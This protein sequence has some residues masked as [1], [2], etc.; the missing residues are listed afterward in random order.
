MAGAEGD[1]AEGPEEAERFRGR[2]L[3]L[4]RRRLHGEEAVAPA[5]SSGG[6][7]VCHRVQ[8]QSRVRVAGEVQRAG[9]GLVEQGGGEGGRRG[10]GRRRRRRRGRGSQQKQQKPPPPPSR[11]LS[12]GTAEG[13]R[14]SQVSLIFFLLFCGSKSEGGGGSLATQRTR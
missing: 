5:R 3:P 6:I 12:R 11:R 13:A 8:Q 10:R 14:T 7:V 2:R 9:L 4:L 1:R